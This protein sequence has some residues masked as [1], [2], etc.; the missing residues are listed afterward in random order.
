[1]TYSE[2]EIQKYLRILQN[3]EDGLNVYSSVKDK[4]IP[5]KISQKVSCEN[6][7]NTHFFQRWWFPLL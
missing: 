1:M 7:R 4:H 5:P 3:F 2:E 6:C